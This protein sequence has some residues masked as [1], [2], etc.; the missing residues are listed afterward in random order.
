[1]GEATWRDR[2]VLVTGAAGLLGSSLTRELLDLE[3]EVVVV[4]RD[5]VAWSDL[6]RSD[7]ADRCAVT[8]ADI[9]D[10]EAMTRIVNEFECTSVFHLAAQTIVGVAVRDPVSTF[11]S[12]VRGT[13]TVLEA[14]RRSGGVEGVVVTSS[15]KAYG[16]HTDLPYVEAYSLDGAEVYEAAKVATE[17]VCRPYAVSYGSK[18][19]IARCGNLFGPGDLNWSRLVPGTIRSA[20]RGEAPVIRSD[21]TPVRDYVYV[22]DAAAGLMALWEAIADARLPSGDAVNLSREEPITVLQMVERVLQAS[23]RSDLEPVVLGGAT[24]EIPEQLL[25]SAKAHDALGWRPAWEL[26]DALAE[27]VAWY[28]QYLG[29]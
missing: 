26:D 11:E 25:S 2:R 9:T 3:A 29:A 18:I 15:D 14:A 23:E 17:A 6:F 20:L 4:L 27:T 16:R 22:K 13:W 10:I 28:R 24:D 8:W 12:N 19:G 7:A 21:G 1:M 5:R